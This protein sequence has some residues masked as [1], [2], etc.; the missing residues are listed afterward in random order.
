ML[1]R[2]RAALVS[3]GYQN[4]RYES[5]MLERRNQQA[6]ADPRAQRARKNTLKHS[7]P[8]SDRGNSPRVEYCAQRR[9]LTVAAQIL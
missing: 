7:H 6:D 8:V 5:D 1:V 3:F 9:G 4:Q 2:D